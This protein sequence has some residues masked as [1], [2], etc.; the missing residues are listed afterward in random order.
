[1][2]ILVVDDSK[3]IRLLVAE[4]LKSL[5]HTVVYAENG[6]QCVDFVTQ[7]DVDLILM[8]V[9]MP[10][11]DGIEATRAIRAIKCI[12]WMPIVFLTT[13]GDDDSFCEG[14]AAG[15]DAYLMKPLNPKRLQMTVIAMERIYLMRKDLQSARLKLEQANRELERLSLSDELTGLAN[16]RS[17]DMTLFRRFAWA[18]RRK[19][20][21]ALILCDVDY[22]KAYND[23]YGHPQGDACL[24]SV[25]RAMA[26]HAKRATDLAA[27]YGGEEF[28][29]ILPEEDF[30]S[31]FS[32]AEAMR[33]SVYD[34][35][36]PHARSRA[37]ERVTLSL[38]V[39]V[40]RGQYDSPQALVTAADAALYRAKQ[41]GRNRA[42]ICDELPC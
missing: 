8:D 15:A 14:I 7:Q 17:F 16:R 29:V 13:R 28:A 20:L 23:A 4:C 18:R 36:L 42:E 37:A 35:G 38:G 10:D 40:Y 41:N 9:E 31:A 2:K 27:R 6:R 34:L 3:S 25:A 30:A 12:D 33:R 22:F 24:Q 19:E 5:G 32:L 21:V 1:M 39:A 26:Q 11:L